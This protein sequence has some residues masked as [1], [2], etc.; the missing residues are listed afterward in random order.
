[1]KIL[2]LVAIAL[3]FTVNAHPMNIDYQ[4]ISLDVETWCLKNEKRV[5]FDVCYIN[6]MQAL[7]NTQSWFRGAFNSILWDEYQ[8]CWENNYP[9]FQMI[10][11]CTRKSII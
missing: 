10:S 5:H 8:S 2:M 3:L 11:V 6:Q 7:D 4:A 1:M 9:D